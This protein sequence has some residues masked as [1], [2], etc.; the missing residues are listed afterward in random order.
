VHATIRRAY[1]YA[2]QGLL[3]RRE[4]QRHYEEVWDLA[5]QPEVLTLSEY[6]IGWEMLM[7]PGRPGEVLRF[8]GEVK[9]VTIKMFVTTQPVQQD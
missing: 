8:D 5:H 6:R 7:V 1:Q 2:P 9:S 3:N 4:L